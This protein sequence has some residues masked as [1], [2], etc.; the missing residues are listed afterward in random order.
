[1]TV[2]LSDLAE[3]RIEEIKNEYPDHRSAIMPALFIAQEE[4]GSITAEAVNWVAQKVGVA[5]VH[6][7]EVASFY[8]MYYKKP[9]GKYHFQVC[10]TLSCALR[11]A[12]KITE[13][14]HK[15]FGVKP[16]EVSQ[17]GMWSYEDVECLGSCGTAPMCEVNDRYFENLTPERLEEIIQQ[18]EKEKPELRFS[19]ISD[20]LGD[21]MKNKPRSEVI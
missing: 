16:G 11:G 17:D 7:M 6:V 3:K 13:H 15:R 1:M 12:K 5:P 19:T 10:R 18:I 2:T 21:G 9:V 14:L 4:L 20:A 8:T